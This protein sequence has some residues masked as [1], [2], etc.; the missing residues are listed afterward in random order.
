MYYKK[1]KGR[2]IYLSPIDVDDYEIYTK[3]MNNL[4][5]SRFIGQYTNLITANSERLY[6]E[7]KSTDNHNY[8]IV[9][10]ENDKLIG[11]VSLFDY[12]Q[13][14][15]TAELGIFIGDDE[16]RHKGYG[17]EAIKL[18]LNYGFNYLNI[19]NIMLKVFDCNKNAIEAYKKIGFKQIGKRHEC[20]YYDGKFYDEIYM[21]L[22]KSEYKK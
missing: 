10:E 4:E 18:L 1:I 13:L 5:T 9:L 6:L 17:T 19:N 16:N 2:R 3:W 20:F 12:D 21:E 11:N 14:N 15:Q 22:L 8:A 7:K